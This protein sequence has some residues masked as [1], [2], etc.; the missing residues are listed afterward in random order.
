MASEPLAALLLLG[1]GYSILSVSP[2]RLAQMRWLVRQ[3][4][5]SE[6]RKISERTLQVATTQR[7]TEL[8]TEGLRSR[9][10]L[11]VLQAGWLPDQ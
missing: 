4:D 10:D 8:L 2:P 7:V 3:I 6:A 9:I 5:V 11:G 1:L